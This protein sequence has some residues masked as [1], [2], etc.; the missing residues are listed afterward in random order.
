[1]TETIIQ[2][3]V[4]TAPELDMDFHIHVIPVNHVAQ[5]WSLVES[6]LQEGL[7]RGQETRTDYTIDQV[8]SYLAQG[9]WQLIVA[10]D[11]NGDVHGA[12]AVEFINRPNDRVAF[13]V[14]IGGRLVISE[15]NAEQFYAILRNCGA[16]LIELAARQ[17]AARLFRMW[18]LRDKYTVMEKA[19]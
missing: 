1:M 7:E 16:T 10:C 8:K 2:K 9:Y 12:C 13:I 18:G 5:A 3:P 4:E 6:F 11:T 19:L 17:S 14:T 15:S